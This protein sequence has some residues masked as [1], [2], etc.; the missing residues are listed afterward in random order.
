[1]NELLR[2][3]ELKKWFPVRLGFMG[4]L[5]SRKSLFVRAVDG[6][7]FDVKEQEIFGLVGESGSGKTTTGRAIL[8][9][10]E[11]TGGKIF[12]KGKEVTH[13]STRQFK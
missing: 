4:T 9:L 10:T 13:L 1:M 2:V 8:R 12:F 6:I 11:P 7:S 3:E 5:L